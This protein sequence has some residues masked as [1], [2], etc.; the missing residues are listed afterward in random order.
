M[1][2][3]LKEHCY[4]VSGNEASLDGNEHGSLR[5]LDFGA[6][7]V[8]IGGEVRL[9]SSASN[10]GSLASSTS[11][12]GFDFLPG[13]KLAAERDR[14]G[15]YDAYVVADITEYVKSSQAEPET[16]CLAGFDMLVS[17]NALSFG[18][19]SAATLK[20][21]VSLVQSR[22]LILFRHEDILPSFL[23]DRETTLLCSSDCDQ[24]HVFRFIV[25]GV[26]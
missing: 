18:D 19:T 21:A 2:K 3:M 23:G 16:V 25:T 17:V 11:V 14:P 4:L 9:V 7:N 22:W 1:I 5:A 8:M 15:V 12:V 13:A 10:N 20:A 24:A 6:G 26:L